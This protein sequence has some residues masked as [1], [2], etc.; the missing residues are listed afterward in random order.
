M[1][2][3]KDRKTVLLTLGRLPKALEMARALHAVGCRVLVADPS[4]LHLCRPSNAVDRCFTPPAPATDQDGYLRDLLKITKE[5][6]VDLVVPISEES[7]HVTLLERNLPPSVQIFSNCHDVLA[8]LSDKYA[9]NRAAEAAGCTVPETHLANSPDARRLAA[10]APCVF[11]PRSGCSGQQLQML[12][13]DTLPESVFADP[14]AIIQKRVFGREVST[15]SLCREGRILAHVTYEGLVFSGTVAVCF[16]RVDDAPQV[17]EWVSDFVEKGGYSYFLAFDF[18]VDDNGVP[19]PL[20][21]NPRLTSGLHFLD[22][23][24][25]GGA[26]R[27]LSETR[28]VG[29]KS[30][31]RFQEG[32]TTLL[33]VYSALF[34][35]ST[36]LKR[37]H[38]MITS[39]DVL[40]SPSDPLPFP[41]M[42]VS[43]WPVLKQVLFG[44]RTFGE[45][46]THDIVW[47]SD[48]QA[49]AALHKPL[50]AA[51]W[52]KSDAS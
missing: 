27:G 31:R 42:T 25:L 36:M 49:E 10:S 41:L 48:Q 22:P 24:D 30:R 28:D 14:S 35:P 18:I 7:L 52:V 50:T 33:Q 8:T 3:L 29:L 6:N 40:W 19:W 15:L 1:S 13:P 44:G 11:K 2:D 45:A 16:Q 4:S 32:H 51:E 37:A 12:T 43:S 5:E 34:R 20:E 17:A 47:P 21:C 26:V 39:R 23:A 46:A 38:A 9:F